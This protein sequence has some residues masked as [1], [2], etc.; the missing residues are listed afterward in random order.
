MS[1]PL[2]RAALAE[3]LQIEKP[4]LR[5][6][7]EGL[8]PFCSRETRERSAAL[9]SRTDLG[10]LFVVKMLVEAGFD[11]EQFKPISAALY[12]RMATPGNAKAARD[13]V[14][15][16]TTKWTLDAR[17]AVGCLTMTIPLS[18]A[19][20]AADRFWTGGAPVQQVMSLG[21]ASVGTRSRSTRRAA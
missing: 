19:A 18:A 16:F 20:E 11:L 3:A 1:P 9:Y 17:P 13:V 10:F 12:K 5:R 4:Q 15:Q 8:E 21:V 14:L 6:W 2:R 7:L